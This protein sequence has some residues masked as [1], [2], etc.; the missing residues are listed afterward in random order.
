[1]KIFFSANVNI[2]YQ[3]T[4]PKIQITNKY[5]E[6]NVQCLKPFDY[7]YFKHCNLFES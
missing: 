3:I 7:L 1:M 6:L 2:P 4:N 5:Q